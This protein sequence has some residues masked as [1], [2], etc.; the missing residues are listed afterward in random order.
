MNRGPWKQEIFVGFFMFVSLGMN[1]HA[2][3]DDILKGRMKLGIK[4][5]SWMCLGIHKFISFI[6]FTWMW[7]KKELI[8]WF[9]AAYKNNLVLGT[10]FSVGAQSIGR[11][12]FPQITGGIAKP[13][14]WEETKTFLSAAD[15]HG[16]EFW[17]LVNMCQVKKSLTF[18]RKIDSFCCWT[19]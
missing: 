6:L 8:Q 14:V 18:P 11:G 13:L 1:G 12:G 15:F 5:I 3:S 2:Q 9:Q 17:V 10:W 4:L 7:S 16:H 19:F